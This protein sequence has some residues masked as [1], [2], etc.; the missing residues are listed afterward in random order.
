MVAI[1]DGPHA[2]AIAR[3][4]DGAVDLHIHTAP[5]PFPRRIDVLEAA[6]QA[7][8]VGFKAVVA[9]SHHHATII[10]V[11]A[12]RPHGLDELDIGVYA[13]I[14]L[15]SAVGGLNPHAVDQALKMGSR[16]VWFP[17]IAAPRHIEHHHANPNMKFP[18]GTFRLMD[19][20][21]ADVFDAHGALRPEIH[22]IIELVR[23]SDA[24]LATGHMDP[25]SISAVLEAARAAGVRRLLVNHPTFVVGATLA[26]AKY[27]VELGAYIEHSI[28]IFDERSTFYQQ[29]PSDLALWLREIG[30]E[31]TIL[32]SDLGQVNNPLPVEAYMR[33]LEYL[34]GAGFSE[35]ELRPVVQDNP[36]RMLNV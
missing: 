5:S 9:K 3:L 10:D 21:P 7:Q 29:E 8:A 35:A 25:P 22:D 4:L 26:E 24:F 12:L 28:C 17:T 6:R 2:A 36:A 15:N 11:L 1:P 33:V 34:L 32:G 23:D 13:G 27:W 18:T 19:E 30:P 14:A 16:A 20:A 31:R